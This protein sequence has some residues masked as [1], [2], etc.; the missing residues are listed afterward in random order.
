MGIWAQGPQPKT[1]STGPV[2]RQH[3]RAAERATVRRPRTSALPVAP[4]LLTQPG[5]TLSTEDDCRHARQRQH[6]T[7]HHKRYPSLHDF[8]PPGAGRASTRFMRSG[9]GACSRHPVVSIVAAHE[10]FPCACP[11]RAE[12]GLCECGPPT[13]QRDARQCRQ[14]QGGGNHTP[15][16]ERW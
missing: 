15:C 3:A 2:R 4:P 5:L 8:P 16:R 6:N 12:L 13:P 11:S 7:S 1:E 14:E 9:G 10:R